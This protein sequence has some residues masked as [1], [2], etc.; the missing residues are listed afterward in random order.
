MGYLALVADF[1]DGEDHGVSVFLQAVMNAALFKCAGVV[2]TEA[3]TNV[4]VTNRQTQ[5]N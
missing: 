5:V 2:D 4:N 1:F 3:T